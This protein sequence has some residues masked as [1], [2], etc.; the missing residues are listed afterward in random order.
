MSGR[1]NHRLP[2]P[3]YR[4]ILA[5]YRGLRKLAGKNPGRG[6]TLPDFVI[7]GAAKAGTTSIYAWLCQ[8]PYVARAGAKEIHYFSWHHDRG[9]DW[10]RSHFP[11]ERDRASFT[12]EHDRP[13]ATGE[14]SPTYLPSPNAPLRM[15]TLIPEVKLIVVLRDPV[16]RA[17]SQFQMRRR[18]G[19]E[20]V[21]SFAT[22]VALEDERVDGGR[23]RALSTQAKD[24]QLEVGRTYLMRGRYAEQLDRWFQYFPREQFHVL[25][26]DQLAADSQNALDGLHNF[27]GLPSHRVERL[28]ARFATQYDPLASEDRELLDEYFREPNERLCHLLGQDFGWGS[29]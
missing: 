6:R 2:R 16:D 1:L 5:G 8:H 23:A 18:D 28:E 4:S 24:G 10:Y 29:K 9:A 19:F 27:L 3:A 12:A 21:D 11:L 17:Y 26:T 20:P 7:I 13:F 14:G 25:T 22:A 15:A